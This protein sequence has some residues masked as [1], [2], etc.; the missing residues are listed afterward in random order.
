LRVFV[1]KDTLK[2]LSNSVEFIGLAV[3]DS[4]NIYM[5]SKHAANIV[6]VNCM[7]WP[8][9]RLPGGSRFNYPG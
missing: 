8:V 1:L 3:A 7:N 9:T 6:R 2:S 5:L 4:H